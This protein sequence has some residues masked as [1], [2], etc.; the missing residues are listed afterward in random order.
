MNNLKNYVSF[1]NEGNFLEDFVSDIIGKNDKKSGINQIFNFNTVSL[2]KWISDKIKRSD[3]SPV[4]IYNKVNDSFPFYV[5]SKFHDSSKLYGFEEDELGNI[6]AGGNKY[7]YCIFNSSKIDSF[8][9]DFLLSDLNKI[10][11]KNSEDGKKT[12]VE[13]TNFSSL[14]DDEKRVFS[15]VISERR[16]GAYNLKPGE[17]F[18]FSDNSNS[19]KGGKDLSSSISSIINSPGL[20]LI[21]HDFSE[22]SENP[23]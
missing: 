16:V 2:F 6:T 1:L 17:F 9:P 14:S 8:S 22:T 3:D 21:N 20:S 13:I 15:D 5:M 18:I 11:S 12:I 10:L 7:S 4:Y 19:Q 23:E